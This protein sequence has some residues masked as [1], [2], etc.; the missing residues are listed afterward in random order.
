MR[1]IEGMYALSLKPDLKGS[2]K[3]WFP[4]NR[5]WGMLLLYFSSSDCGYGSHVLQIPLFIIFL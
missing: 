1:C 4:V 3:Y 2:S 5:G